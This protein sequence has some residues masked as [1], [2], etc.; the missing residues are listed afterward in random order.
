MPLV[1]ITKGNDSHIDRYREYKWELRVFTSNPFISKDI[2][3][4]SLPV[5]HLRV[6]AVAGLH[7]NESKT[8]Q[9]L[10]VHLQTAAE[11]PGA[12]TPR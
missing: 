2:A 3:S 7:M 4:K 9:T 11:L 10:Y 6:S 5:P 12:H 1:V 8:D